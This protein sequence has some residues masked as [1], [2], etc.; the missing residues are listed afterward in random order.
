MQRSIIVNSNYVTCNIRSP[1]RFKIHIPFALLVSLVFIL[2]ILLVLLSHYIFTTWN[3]QCENWVSVILFIWWFYCDNFINI[4]YP[5]FLEGG[6]YIFEKGG[7]EKKT[8]DL[9]VG[10]VNRSRKLRWCVVQFFIHKALVV[11]SN[12]YSFQ[13]CMLT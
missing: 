1:T 11:R 5:F 10:G 7:I 3:H 4:R 8:G 2:L 13:R 9:R 6:W 12:L